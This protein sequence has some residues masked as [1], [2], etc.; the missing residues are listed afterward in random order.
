MGGE[1]GTVPVA[2]ELRD[3]A[4]GLVEERSELLVQLLSIGRGR[5]GEMAPLEPVPKLF[6]GIQLGSITGEFHR[7]QSRGIDDSSGRRVRFP[8]VPHHDHS[9]P[10]VP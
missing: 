6:D 2:L 3:I 7:L 8:T 5:I 4:G 9:A 1:F 10:E